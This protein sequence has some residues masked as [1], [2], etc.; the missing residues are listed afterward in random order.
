MRIQPDHIG[1]EKMDLDGM[2]AVE[3]DHIDL[4]KK[5]LNILNLGKLNDTN[6]CNWRRAWL[7]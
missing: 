7:L 6:L 5:I 4:G 3:S 2:V 1:M